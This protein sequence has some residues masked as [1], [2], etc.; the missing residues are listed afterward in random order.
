MWGTEWPRYEVI[1]Q[2]TPKA[3]PQMVGSVHAADPEHALLIA[4]HV[5]VRRPSC[6]A[7]FVA[8]A[9][10]FFHITQEGLKDPEALRPK[11]PGPEEAYWVFAKRGHRRSM[12]YGDLVGRFAASSPEE[13]V[14]QALLQAQGVAFWAVPE[15][16]VVGTEPTA[17]VVESWFAP[18]KEKTYRLQ[19][20]YGLITAKEVGDDA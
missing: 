4:R 11:G 13:A 1:K 9:E 7:L 14:A 10:A 8:P 20:Y 12:V 17:E 2:D 3:L 16:E 15:R 5:F 18:A 19:S 6:Y